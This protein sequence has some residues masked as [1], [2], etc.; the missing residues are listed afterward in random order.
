MNMVSFDWGLL[1]ETLGE[2]V[3]PITMILPHSDELTIEDE[4]FN[5]E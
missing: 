2:V 4:E 5:I 3:E 1:L